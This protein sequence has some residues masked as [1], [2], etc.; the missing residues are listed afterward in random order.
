MLDPRFVAAEPDL[1]K[2]HLTRRHAGDDAFASVDRIVALTGRRTE[3]VTEQGDLRAERNRLSKE[4]GGLFKQGKRDEAEAAKAQVQEVNARVGV[5][6]QELALVEGEQRDLAMRLPNLLDDAVPEGA[7]DEDNIEVSRWGTPRTFDF[8]PEAHVEVGDKLGILDMAKA[9]ELSGA[10]FSLLKGYGARLERALI[11]FFLDLHTGEHGYTE[12]QVPV[13]VQKHVPFGTGQLPKFSDD[14]FKLE[15]PLNGSPAYLIPTAEVPVT[16]LHRESILEDGEMNRKY[17]T[18][19]PCFRSEAGSAGKDVRGLMRVHQ[20]H[21]VELVQITRPED[22]EAAHEEMVG[23]AEKCLQLLGLPYRKMLLCGGDI[24]FGARKCYDLEVWVPSQDRYREISSIS[25]C[26]DFQGRR[27]N[28]RCRPAQAPGEKKK[29]KPVFVHTLNGSALAVGRTM[30]ALLE[31][32]QQA[33]GSV[34]IP[35]VLRPYMGVDVLRP[36]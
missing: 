12:L 3:L 32:Y 23:Q 15:Q 8:T 27:M 7:S 34:E 28:T 33:D 31:N 26:G 11:N 35:E 21:K 19:T 5:I 36:Q 4:I 18:F 10:R 22:S 9:A 17:V 13:I 14:M 30:L 29:A 2:Q 16:N 20:F 24:G 25:N 1:V 6:E